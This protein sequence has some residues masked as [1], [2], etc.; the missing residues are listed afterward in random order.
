MSRLISCSACCLLFLNIAMAPGKV[1]AG[2]TAPVSELAFVAQAEDDSPSAAPEDAPTEEE[3]AKA[4]EPIA[5]E[6][7]KAQEVNA[8]AEPEADTEPEADKEQAEESEE[9]E[10]DEEAGKAKEEEEKG[11]KPHKVE[12]KPLKI[13]TEV[14]AVLVASEMAEVALRPEVWTQ[15]EVVEAVEH[16]ARVK[17]G[18]VLVRFDDEK[19]EK[20][21]TGEMLDQQLGELAM[22][23]E[24]EDF[25]REKK[26]MELRFEE[27]RRKHEQL[28]EDYELYQSTD[29][30]HFVEVTNYRYQEAQENLASQREEL[31]Q[32]EKMYAA[33]ELTEET[34]AI[35]LRRQRFEVETAELILKL[36]AADRDYALN[37]SLPRRDEYYATMLR[38]AE[39]TL[40]Q[41]K[42]AKEV[43]LTRGR[44][45][46]EKKREARAN[47][48]DRHSKLVSD[49]G[50]MVLRAP[51]D[52]T[53]YYGACS[54]GKWQEVASYATKLIPFGVVPPNKVIMTVVQQRPLYVQAA[55]SE[56]ELPDFI[57]G[58]SATV[59]PAGDSELEL[60]GKVTEVSAV[61]GG[62]RKFATLIEVDM[63]D[64]PDWLVAGMT[65]KAN[66]TVYEN[67]AA[68]V[69]P[70]ELVQT[71][72]DNKKSKYVMLVDRETEKPVRRDVKLGREKEKL[73]EVLSGLNEGDEIVE[74]EKS[75]ED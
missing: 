22:M 50:L 72:E 9:T 61:P 66:V 46:L 53:V 52:G 55:L 19:L 26:L 1:L 15:F 5:Q 10:G 28:L 12:R 17:K 70:T 4:E 6:E 65:C 57:A 67:A 29:R 68:L 3:V 73:V 62:D 59:V 47:S 39:I 58:Q 13:E 74:E 56:K 37:V 18:D 23:S 11:P 49:R 2:P 16:G 60:P 36:Q 8:D 7:A 63:A 33:D 31:E 71:D 21:L 69:I 20:E 14:D 48:V 40:E 32:L 35:V 64:A 43:G 25:P 41:A 54:E 44:Y 34:E 38:E 24:E 51:V 75:D 27:A 42:S 30:P 45:E